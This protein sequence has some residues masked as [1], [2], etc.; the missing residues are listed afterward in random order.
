MPSY[1]RSLTRRNRSARQSLGMESLERRT[2]LAGNV[3]AQL[4]GPTLLLTGDSLGNAVV[5]ASVAGGKFAVVSD[6]STTINGSTEPF[7]T[8]KS[9][10][11]IV[12]NLGA[13]NDGISFS[14]T[15]Q[16]V[17]D[18]L[19]ELGIDPPPFDVKGLQSD[20]DAVAAGATRFVLPGSLT[21]TTASGTDLVS[22]IGSVGGSVAVN[23]GSAP[24]GPESGNALFIGGSIPAHA[25][26]VNGSMPVYASSIGGALS[27]VGG[28]QTDFV[29]LAN[30]MVAGGVS[31]AL[32]G[33]ANDCELSESSVGSLTYTGGSG[34]DTIDAF[35]VRVR[36]GVS[37]VTGAGE[38]DVYLHEHGG[39]QTVV[40]GSL[41]VDTGAGRDYVE[42]SAAV[43]GV[44]SLVTGS[45]DDEVRIYETSVGL[46][47]V[48]DTGAG[49]DEASIRLSRIR[50]SL[51]AAMGVG[52]DDLEIESTTA[53]AG[54]LYGG[55]GR[56]QLTIDPASRTG[57]RRLYSYQFMT[58]T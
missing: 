52:N 53:F 34:A 51:I 18:Q 26:S 16:G 20:I 46:N 5:V 58:K 17:A 14:N 45:G 15:A 33:G 10:R 1:K 39:P 13:G 3:T 56:N 35:D 21:I 25:S 48:I 37:I 11:N 12:A 49:N 32:G 7:V 57:I 44:L 42:I 28:A 55:P 41:V 23:L 50:Y 38:D 40:G 43:S 29:A 19:A 4:L 27:V 36:Y 31:V 9:V 24:T 22:I 30:T 47:A 54:F 2:V 6:G 8:T